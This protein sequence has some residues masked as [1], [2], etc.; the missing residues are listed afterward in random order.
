MINRDAFTSIY[1]ITRLN[2][3]DKVNKN[4]H[5]LTQGNRKQEA[6]FY[7]TC[8][9]TAKNTNDRWIIF[10]H[11]N[12]LT[13]DKVCSVIWYFVIIVTFI[14]TV[15][16]EASFYQW[17]VLASTKVSRTR[18]GKNEQKKSTNMWVKLTK[19]NDADKESIFLSTE[20]VSFVHQFDWG[21]PIKRTHCAMAAVHAAT[22]ISQLFK[23][24][25]CVG[26][27]HVCKRLS[28]WVSEWVCVCA[29][30]NAPLMT[31]VLMHRCSDTTF[32]Y[33]FLHI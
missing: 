2:V 27:V 21:R 18:D 7:H 9:F 25:L 16:T 4:P 28:E 10:L 26:G 13:N 24:T 8:K 30:E 15:F 29:C 11:M 32:S 17:I 22:R 14:Y 5:S 6:K 23:S 31:F 19:I 3:D 12:L 1:V 20:R 33:H